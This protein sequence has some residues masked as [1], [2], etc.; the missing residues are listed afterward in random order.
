[1]G[2]GNFYSKCGKYFVV[3]LPDIDDYFIVKEEINFIKENIIKDLEQEGLDVYEVNYYDNMRDFEGHI[4]ANIDI[5]FEDKEGY[6]WEWKIQLIMRNGYYEGINL[7]YHIKLRDLIYGYEYDYDSKQFEDIEDY[8]PKS[9]W[10]K[11]NSALKKIEKV[12]KK[13]SEEYYVYAKFSNGETWYKKVERKGV[14]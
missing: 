14:N 11:L 6:E 5:E 9:A 8:I 13:Y 10:E 1:M 7:D 3:E 2:T 4:F 12:Y